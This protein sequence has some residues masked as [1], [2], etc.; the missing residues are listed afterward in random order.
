MSSESPS[1]GEIEE[2]VAD[3]H[4]P[5]VV[6]SI[7]V[8]I[9]DGRVEQIELKQGDSPEEVSTAFCKQHDLPL[10]F[11]VP[12]TE[13]ITYN[14]RSINREHQR[15]DGGSPKG[16][17]GGGGGGGAAE[18]HGQ[19]RG[20]KGQQKQKQLPMD[21]ISQARRAYMEKPKTLEEF[22]KYQA[23]RRGIK[24]AKFS[25]RLLQ[26]TFT[27]S[28][29][30]VD[31]GKK[32]KRHKRK[33]ELSEKM[34]A[35]CL[36][37]YTDYIRQKQRVEEEA[38][39]IAEQYHEK[40]VK[41]RPVT[42]LRSR[43]LMRNREREAEQFQNYGE[44][45]YQ[46]AVAKDQERRRQIEKKQQE[47]E[48]N[49]LKLISPKPE[50]SKLAKRLKRTEV[51]WERLVQDK[52]NQEHLQELRNE[53][54]EAK[55]MECTFKPRINYLHS[56]ERRD[57]Q[58]TTRF[59]QLFYDAE[60]RRRRQAEY[61]QW[62]PE[63][64][65][66]HPHINKTGDGGQV[67]ESNTTVFDRLLQYAERLAEKKQ[68]LLEPGGRKLID[69]TTGQE[70]FT[71]TI[72]RQPVGERN[73]P[74]GEFLYQ[75]KFAM[76]DKKKSLMD[77]DIQHRIELA[78]SHYV[79]TKSGQLLDHLKERRLKQIFDHLDKDKSGYVDLE[80][81]DTALFS[82]EVVDEIKIVMGMDDGKGSLSY[83]T[84]QKLMQTAQKKIVSSGLHNVFKLRKKDEKFP[85]QFK[86]CRLSRSLAARRRKFSTRSQWYKL[87]LLDRQERIARVEALRKEKQKQEMAECT[88][89]PAI[90]GGKFRQGMRRSPYSTNSTIVEKEKQEVHGFIFPESQGT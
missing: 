52:Q 50:I 73:L 25:E 4:D 43:R 13:H 16:K 63:G 72:G 69:P 18:E 39:L 58:T 20:R 83:D 19:R 46:E 29:K 35:L 86:M 7:T 85:F 80:K 23:A 33:A 17:G 15:G 10:Q 77:R 78:K 36:R 87:I 56:F 60:H 53:L 55:L 30:T 22:R 66:F 84:F 54:W 38:R 1:G 65:T 75:M 32:E 12:L 48:M 5:R 44:L 57:V 27:F 90:H 51:V 82:D 11:V 28:T 79:G 64:V 31:R 76:E 37:L 81:A 70:F 6:L 71:P 89:T 47:D 61:M 8:E 2:S 74:I 14:L 41:D 34:K 26:H 9:E 42:S 49:E 3:D 21:V 88:F 62:Y 24:P 68:K 67:D 45:L 59:E 40:M